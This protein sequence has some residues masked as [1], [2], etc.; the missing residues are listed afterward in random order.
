MSRIFQIE[1]SPAHEPSTPAHATVRP[2]A[3]MRAHPSGKG[4]GKNFQ[5]LWL[6]FKVN[7][8]LVDI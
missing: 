3:R 6:G 7:N 2:S 5:Y 4:E 1:G 8:I